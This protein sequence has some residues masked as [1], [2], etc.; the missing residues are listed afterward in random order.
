MSANHDRFTTELRDESDCFADAVDAAARLGAR[1]GF[2]ALSDAWLMT[3]PTG[4][5]QGSDFAYIQ[6]V[7]G[8]PERALK[9][10]TVS[11]RGVERVPRRT[12][13]LFAAC[14]AAEPSLARPAFRVA[15]ARGSAL[16]RV[17]TAS[18]IVAARL[19][20]VSTDATALAAGA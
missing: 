15:V 18:M 12:R 14:V 8:D 16:D 7:G 9:A 5:E 2:R 19:A 17:R 10:L 6:L 13:A 1:A 4:I 20:R 3:D 11:S